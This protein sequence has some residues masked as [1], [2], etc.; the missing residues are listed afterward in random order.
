M[1]QTDACLKCTICISACPV[2]RQDTAFPGPKALGP[3][4]YR[5]DQAGEHGYMEHVDD[6]TFCQLCELACPVGV[7]IAHLIAE[8][9][10]QARAVQPAALR[11]RDTVLTHPEWVARAPS[12]SRTPRGVNRL[13]GLSNRSQRPRPRRARAVAVPPSEP[14]RG[15]VGLFV[16]CFNRGFDQET[17]A[18]ASALLQVWGF[19]VARV[20]GESRCCGAAAYASGRPEQASAQAASMRASLLRVLPEDSVALVTLNATCDGTIDQE[21]AT[22]LGV[23]ALSVPI[24]PFHEFALQHAPDAFWQGLSS[25]GGAVWTHTTCRGRRR[26]EGSLVALAKRAGRTE[27]TPLALTC[28]GAAGSYAFKA[29][30][31]AV[32][33]GMAEAARDQVADAPGD[34]WVDSGTCAV[35]LAQ[36]SGQP[37]RHPAVWLYQQWVESQ[38][39]AALA[40]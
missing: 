3:E 15:R 4:W 16:D 8:Q 5:R 30:H 36:V 14:S 32:A 24:V 39:K 21:W 37:A 34:I 9:K 27:V 33:H 2:Y 28:C 13:L 26:G 40:K 10:N 20:P 22:Y 17:V 38:A 18:A 11:L 1:N 29:E 25:E 23:D 35:H 19:Q 6:C 31:E 12:L 7:P